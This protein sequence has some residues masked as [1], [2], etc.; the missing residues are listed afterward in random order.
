MCLLNKEMKFPFIFC[1]SR[2]FWSEDV[3]DALEAEIS[4][5][6][7]QLAPVQASI[8][9]TAPTVD[10][11]LVQLQSELTE[12]IQLSKQTLLELKKEELLSKLKEFEENDTSGAS[13][14]STADYQPK[15][16]GNQEP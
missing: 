11:E 10:D 4:V 3:M 2:E 14:T 1:T 7:Q 8:T 15:Q 12:L 6:E 16:D 13:S 5:S 9:A